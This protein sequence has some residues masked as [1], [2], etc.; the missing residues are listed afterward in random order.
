MA[1]PHLEAQIEGFMCQI[2]RTV[3]QRHAVHLVVSCDDSNGRLILDA[4]P[5]G[6]S[7]WMV[8]SAGRVVTPT[9]NVVASDVTL[10]CLHILRAAF[11]ENWMERQ[12]LRYQ[13]KLVAAKPN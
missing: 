11:D 1:P 6:V 3:T 2:R 7:S 10:T 13:Q 5:D 8:R 12:K 4:V 9:M